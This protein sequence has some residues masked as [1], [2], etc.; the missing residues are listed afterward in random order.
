MR[1]VLNTKS[2]NRVSQIKG[3]KFNLLLYEEHSNT[4]YSNTDFFIMPSS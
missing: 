1:Q 3:F 4:I 2:Q